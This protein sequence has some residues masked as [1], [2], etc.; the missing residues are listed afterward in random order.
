MCVSHTKSIFISIGGIYSMKFNKLEFYNSVEKGNHHK[1]QKMISAKPLDEKTL[2][3]SLFLALKNN[4]LPVANVL[5]Q[6][7]AK[8]CQPG[9]KKAE[10]IL[11]ASY[12]KHVQS[13]FHEK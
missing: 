10:N 6:K 1:V 3:W 4:H 13:I 5:R 2:K 8:L 12:Q 11:L 9:I 7:G